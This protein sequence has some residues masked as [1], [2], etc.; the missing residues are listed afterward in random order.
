VKPKINLEQEIRDWLLN[1]IPAVFQ[2]AGLE[3][4]ADEIARRPLAGCVFL[5]GKLTKDLAAAAQK[6]ECLILPAL[7]DLVFDPY[8]ATL[9]DADTLFDQ[10]DPDDPEKSFENC[11]DW[12]IY[13]KHYDTEKHKLRPADIDVMLMRRLHDASVNAALDEML[14]LSARTRCVAV[15]GGHD[16]PRYGPGREAYVRAAQLGLALAE[17]GYLVITGGGPGAMEAANLGA[18]CAGFEEPRRVLSRAL[19][20][21]DVEAPLN[22]PG[23]WL[24][25]AWKAWKEMQSFPHDETKCSNV[26][27]PTWFYGHEPPNVFAT[28][29][30][31]Y[32]EN[33]VR[34]EGL[35]G[36]ALAGI[37]FIRGNAGT[38]QEIF[39]DACQNYYKTYDDVRS[40]MVLL[41]KDYW[42]PAAEK[43]TD[44]NDRT[45][46]AYPLLWKMAWEKQFEKLICLTDTVDEAVAFI[47][48]NPPQKI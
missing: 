5:G 20:V 47:K 22:Q 42:N 6:A 32:F 11:L 31:K 1:P 46:R 40:P 27:I 14:D 44:P 45:K 8:R 17:E 3:K 43:P 29:I 34:E 13:F 12:R 23:R 36:F 2:L 28:H 19:E 21:L 4:Y 38:V 35:L 15:M 24:A 48:N 16:L 26:G 41:E 7:G 10:F 33:S 25:P 9:Y 18:Y 30:A 37:V 39:Q